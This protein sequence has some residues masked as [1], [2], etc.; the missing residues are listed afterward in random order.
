MYGFVRRFYGATLRIYYRLETIGEPLPHEG[1]VVVVGSHPNALCDVNF[2]MQWSHRPLRFLAKAPIFRMPYIGWC[3]RGM[4]A[5]PVKRRQDDPA[6]L[7]GNDE[8]FTA[9]SD[10]L[11][12]GEIIAVFPEGRSHA[13]PSLQPLTRGAAHLALRAEARAGFSLGVRIV[14]VGISYLDRRFRNRALLDAGAPLTSVDL[15]EEYRKSPRRAAAILTERIT[16]ELE[17]RTLNLERWDDLATLDAADRVLG[18]AGGD[19]DLLSRR[20]PRLRALNE[21][22]RGSRHGTPA[23]V[24]AGMWQPQA[25]EGRPPHSA[26]ARRRAVRIAADALGVIGALVWLVPCAIARLAA[27]VARVGPE[28]RATFT[29]ISAGATVPAWYVAVVAGTAI[30]VEW[31]VA[32][33][34]AF[35]L[36]CVGAAALGLATR[37]NVRRSTRVTVD[38]SA[39]RLI[40]AVQPA[41]AGEEG[42]GGEG[43]ETRKT[44]DADG[45][46]GP[47]AEVGI[48]ASG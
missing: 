11:A 30:A 38:D 32:V 31:W 6:R 14:P 18:A 20:I 46:H 10:A 37:L 21:V 12:A 3:A 43:T 26:H 19:D 34:S 44:Q 47:P 5:I 39:R 7:D 35:V 41:Q 45:A 4:R 13:H 24:D 48:P 33:M 2:L 29:I 17:Q 15:A 28:G 40:A 27:I 16:Q 9:T 36:P 1:P 23:H 42:S 8:M 22:L 25:G